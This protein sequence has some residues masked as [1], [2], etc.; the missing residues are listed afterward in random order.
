MFRTPQDI[1]IISIDPSLRS[2]GV[3]TCRSGKCESYSIQRK[4]DRMQT[5]GYYIRRM[6]E[7]AKEGWDLLII[8]GYSMGSRSSSVTVAAE[9]GGVIR[10]CFAARSIPIIEIPPMTW[11]AITGIKLKKG[12]ATEKRE[13]LNACIEKFSFTFDTTDECDAFYMFWS[14]VESSRGN[15][16]KG[17]GSKLNYYLEEIKIK[18]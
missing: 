12:S 13:Y 14:A 11:K 10:A 7:I 5:L 6:N 8:E 18:L 1:N 16:R 17:I 15:T 2:T 4:T 3:F 9:V